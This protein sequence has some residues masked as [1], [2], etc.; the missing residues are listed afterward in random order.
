VGAC[1]TDSPIVATGALSGIFGWTCER[2]TINGTLLLA[3]T[4]PPTIQSLR[5]AAV[6]RR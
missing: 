1:R 4:N 5:L 2:G 3:P 6:P